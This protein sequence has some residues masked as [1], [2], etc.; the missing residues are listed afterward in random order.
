M[1]FCRT[2]LADDATH[3]LHM[4]LGNGHQLVGGRTSQMGRD[5][6]EE[7][8]SL[9]AVTDGRLDVVDESVSET[10]DIDMVLTRLS[11]EEVS[12]LLEPAISRTAT[13]YKSA[14]TPAAEKSMILE[15]AGDY[16]D[17]GLSQSEL[18][19]PEQ[20]STPTVPT[21]PR[22]AEI[23][24]SL[25]TGSLPAPEVNRGIPMTP[26]KPGTKKFQILDG[27]QPESKSILKGVFSSRTRSLSGGAQALRKMLPKGVPSMSSVGN[28]FSPS[29]SPPKPKVTPQGSLLPRDRSTRNLVMR[30]EVTQTS[31]VESAARFVPIAKQ[32]RVIDPQSHHDNDDVDTQLALRRSISE[33]GLYHSLS[34]ASSLGDD[35][36]FEEQ[37]EMINS[38]SKAIRDSWQDRSS[39]RMPQMPQLPSIPSMPRLSDFN[40]TRNFLANPSTPPRL[41]TDTD[42]GTGIL[43]AYPNKKKISVP[44]SPPLSGSPDRA[45]GLVDETLRT[46]T[47]TLSNTEVFDEAIKDLT[48]DVVIMGGYRGSVLRST[49]TKRQVWVP[50][51]V[52]LNIR[53]VDLEVGLEPEDDENMEDTIYSSGMLQNIGP[54]DIAKRLFKRLRETNNAKN[55]KLRIWDYGYDWRLSPHYLSRR[56][57][58]FLKTLPS[59]Q[60]GG[61]GAL[62]IA[63]SLGGLITRHVVNRNP[64]LV[65]GVIYAG[66]PNGCI[67]ILGPLRNGDA[68]ML[69]SRVLTA[70]VNFTLRTSF[71]LLPEDG[72]CFIDINTKDKYPIDF[73]DVNE[74]IKYRL[75]PCTDAPLPPRNTRAP[76]SGPFDSLRNRSS[77]IQQKRK[78]TSVALKINDENDRSDLSTSLRSPPLSAK[79]LQAS[80]ILH[81]LAPNQDRTIGMQMDNNKSQTP[82][83]ASN[84][85]SISTTVTIPRPAAIAYLT[86]ILSE[87]KTFKQEMHFDPTLEASNRYPPA[88][89]IYGKSIPTVFGAKVDGREGIACSDCYDN[90]AFASGDGVCLAKEAMLPEGYKCVSGGRIS[91]DRGHITLLGD[92]NAVGRA[93]EAVRRG[94]ARGIGLGLRKQSL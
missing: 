70:Q 85:Q 1:K 36:R 60:P 45:P 83:T 9:V 81:N 63:H 22:S 58:Q 42:L 68:V 29:S 24:G 93:I 51:K 91:S 46:A 75:S 64:E 87:I 2:I 50:V 74:W 56:L 12:T 86:R 31:N 77:S 10:D 79:T 3:T 7:D 71:L 15:E 69:S 4:M 19:S 52:G 8:G 41:I 66:T 26:W 53:K 33:S 11:T 67:N 48:G 82:H 40:F 59:N 35:T 76:P 94:R 17:T 20:S 25:A 55:G 73:F 44:P 5:G 65:S 13:H 72:N 39:F 88:A 38:R 6:R 27:P 30:P 89:I 54:V 90:L 84:T 34:R 43:S 80:E 28:M 49:K 47:A 37:T 62:V 92:L 18:P 61:D 57:E 16:F 14:R 32:K 23:G 78:P 21:F